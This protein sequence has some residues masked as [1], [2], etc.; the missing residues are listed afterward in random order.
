MSDAQTNSILRHVRQLAADRECAP[1]TD[2]D[3]LQR[4]ALGR[5]ETAFATLVRRHGTMVLEV[6][7]RVL[8]N[9][10][11]A[12]D[13]LQAT[14]L[15]LAR[16]A[17]A[18][19]WQAS[20]GSWLHEVAGRL[21]RKAKVDAARRLARLARLQ[22]RP[23]VKPPPDLGWQAV[24]DEELNR[25]PRQFRAPLMLCYLEGATRDEAAQ[26]LACPLG[27]LK[28][29][30]ERGREMLRARLTRR[31]VTLS[32][33]LLSAGLTQ[34]TSGATAAQLATSVTRAVLLAL[35]SGEAAG[36]STGAVVLARGA[37]RGM[38]LGKLKLSA[39][40]LLALGAFVAGAGLLAHQTLTPQA[41]E[42]LA[43][44]KPAFSPAAAGPAR[45]DD[46]PQARTDRY[47]DPLP[48]EALARLGTLR[49]RH[50]GYL[51]LLAFL[52]D[53]KS[54]I[55]KGFDGIRVWD[56]A[57][58]SEVRQI[59][60]ANDTPA[61]AALSP[62]GKLIVGAGRTPEGTI[63][64]LEAATGKPVR[65]FGKRYF[66][67]IVFSPDGK[68]LAVLCPPAVIELWDPATG[69]SLRTLEGHRNQLWSAAFS[70]D[71]KTLIS[72]GDDKTVRFWEL[73]TGKE[74]LQIVC[75][76]GVRQ[77]A[78]SP[79]GSL[80]AS[81]GHVK[82]E[83]QGISHW[84]PDNHVRIWDASTGKELRS[85]AMPEQDIRPNLP[86][87]FMD[88]HFAP[89][90]T[91]L[92]TG[93]LDGMLRVW[94]AA[95]G[96]QQRQFG[97]FAGA[98]HAFAF[99]PD[100]KTLALADGGATI[101]VIDLV[102]GEDRLSHHGHRTSVG[103]AVLTPDGRAVVTSG[104]DGTLHFWDPATGRLLRQRASPADIVPHLQLIPGGTSY[105]AVGADKILRMHDLETGKEIRAFRWH[106][107]GHDFALS[108]DGRT[109]A[110]AAPDA[111]DIR[112]L[113]A[114]TGKDRQTLRG[115]EP[116]AG[117]FTF[118]PDSRTLFAW[119]PDRSVTV[120]DVA[121]GKNLR[122]HAG[123]AAPLPGGGQP[124]CTARLSPDG[125]LLAFC[126]Q[127]PVLPILD[128]VT[129]KE[130]RRF[131]VAQDGVSGLAFSPDGKTVAWG[132]W[133][134]GTVYLGELATGRE[135][136]RF[137][138]HRG[139]VLALAFSA[140]G[141]TLVS[142]T[143]DTTALVWDLTGRLAAGEKGG[144]TLSPA[145][146]AAHWTALADKDA[147]AGFRALRALVADPARSVPFLAEHLRPAAVVGE[148][149]LSELIADLGSDDFAVREKA[150]EELDKLGEAALDVLRKALA[151]QPALDTRRRLEQLIE[152]QEREDWFP[153]PDR[154]RTLRAVEVLERVGTP[155][156]RRVLE[157]LVN[158]AAGD[159]LTQD[160]LAAR[161]RLSGRSLPRR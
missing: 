108:P 3:L 32:A 50:G 34:Q 19:A 155:E 154:L 55:G 10:H 15:V 12:E 85:L 17:G 144:S 107:S 116:F 82:R 96:K 74:V 28:S 101:R 139:R 159:R 86:A 119:S 142:G 153:S 89:T 95:T 149:R 22:E 61:T 35:G 11:D 39:A 36:V 104:W 141:R 123:S 56:A 73:A 100:G 151:R 4:F 29:R 137:V 121:T 20:V 84:H 49:F 88:M 136:H 63:V 27:T 146:L 122:R 106:D 150:T 124:Y 47:G 52:P 156:A 40:V 38:T 24:L 111:K 1:L 54:L 59:C 60:T 114:T 105:M 23:A 109:F 80:L 127:E 94:D 93:G 67:R 30:L 70:P 120:W 81:I 125:K 92:L 90:G 134:E 51:Q 9:R 18:L 91:T 44:S 14:F 160:A 128:T 143:E 57:T 97:G 8:H 133:S 118:A 43:E 33:S 113:D 112:L 161:E 132:G 115:A 46:R 117:G 129:G 45:P 58:G 66:N 102:S 145:D 68:V 69:A 126:L 6:G 138:G 77:V 130:F 76:E 62:D 53:G 79:D 42:A 78:L 75:P 135:R 148:K 152:K 41:A 13:V 99:T 157:A 71:S 158:G 31:G 5:D 103:S 98:P 7:Q 131:Q 25:L 21:A 2:R 147:A 83:D 72:G 37:L 48:A 65:R 87:G 16:K 140:D 110:E 64:V 26:Q